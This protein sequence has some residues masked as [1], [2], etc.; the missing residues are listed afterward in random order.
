M[1]IRNKDSR[2]TAEKLHK[3]FG[4]ASAIKIVKLIRDADVKDQNLEKAIYEACESCATCGKFKRPTPRPVVSLPM[5][6]RFNDVLA[7]DL[8]AFGGDYFLVMIDQATRFCSAAVIRNKRPS[9]IVKGIFMQWVAIFGAPRKILSDNGGEF[10]NA[11]MRQ[12]GESL[13][14]KMM[15]TAAE[16]PWSNGMCERLNAVLADS[17]RKIID[18]CTCDVDVALAW[19][20][21]ARNALANNCGFSP[22]QLVF[23]CNPVV[24]TVFVNH[25]PALERISA[26]GIVRENLNAMHE[27]RELFIKSEASEKLK[28]ALK[29]NIRES[30]AHDVTNGDEVYYKR[31]GE[32]EW[33]G[34]GTV[35]GRD[36]KQ[37]L[38]KHGG[39]YV[40][41][42]VCRLTRAPQEKLIRE[43][44][45]ESSRPSLS[46]PE[47]ISDDE[48]QP[49][50]PV[51]SEPD[52][53]D[54]NTSDASVEEVD[55]LVQTSDASVDDNRFDVMRARV[56]Q[57]VKGIHVDSGELVTG[58][59]VS[60][61]G[62]VTG[63]NKHCFN[64]KKD[65]DNNVSCFDLQKD[66]IELQEVPDD[67]ELV[68]LF[69]SDSVMSAK[70]SELKN[71]EENEVYEEVENVGQTAISMRWV[72]TEKLKNGEAVTKARLVARGFEEHSLFLRKDSP[73]C[74]RETVRLVLA[75]AVS[76]GWLPHSLDVKAAFLQGDP[77]ERDVFLRPPREFSNGKLWKL[78]KTVYGLCDAARAWYLRVKGELCKLGM[79]PSRYDS[80]IFSWKHGGNLEGFVCVYVDDFLWCGTQKF[81]KEI[82]QKINQLFFIGSNASG[83]FKYV[84][85]NID[86]ANHGKEITVDQI[87]YASTL[88]PIPLSRER[89]NTKS[90]DLTDYEKSEYRSLVGQLNWVATQTRPDI[91]F[92]VCELSGVYNSATV[93]DVIRLN[94]IVSHLISDCLKLRFPQMSDINN[95]CLECY[96]DA[97]FANLSGGGSQGGMI[98]FL[99][100]HKGAS[101]PIYWQTR[102]I[103]RV[104]KSTLSA[105]TMALLDCAEAG[106]FLA[107]VM[108]DITSLA[109]LPVKCYVDNRSLVESL[110]SSKYIE[111]KRLR[112]DIAVISDMLD[113]GEL[114]SVSWVDT[115]S[116]L[117]DPLTKRGASTQRLRDAIAC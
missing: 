64:I 69:N 115:T 61:A 41:A 95:C 31:N 93:G 86:S 105:E 8:K 39:G 101:C 15:C 22:N 12:F 113:R 20:V 42:H 77:I 33:R 53:V 37:V 57:R 107:N 85:L 35:I 1:S 90:S 14:V 50:V 81:Q 24:P 91:A 56:G 82:I 106:I 6:S 66:F 100:D 75:I 97:S 72:I 79:T 74:S 67:V 48:D 17:V 70:E 84:G 83:V 116:Q 102:K 47:V 80:A 104:V 111:D 96:S 51:D 10:N 23:G 109:P 5:A 2:K 36:G 88:Q 58:K 68:I 7:M 110:H 38:V 34:P 78:K 103:R 60:R 108:A 32:D 29:H 117:A 4:H 18:D 62:K 65:S 73:T 28:R 16:S 71:W 98:V 114:H 19:A 45:P 27:A 26:S 46:N 9:T 25:P 40:R 11:E 99:R 87:H 59:I 55:E 49:A 92:E 21:S 3:Q 52:N 94:K 43:Q 89:K 76:K 54:V 44:S 13:N 30:D 63:R 112:L